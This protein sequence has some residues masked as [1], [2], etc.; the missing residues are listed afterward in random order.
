MKPSKCNIVPSS[1]ADTNFDDGGRERDIIASWLQENFPQRKDFKIIFPA[2]YLGFYLGPKSLDPLWAAPICKWNARSKGIAHSHMG[3]T[4]AALKYKSRA[5]S[6]LGYI[7]QLQPPPGS[8]FPSERAN[9]HHML[10]LPTNSWEHNAFFHLGDIGCKN[11]L[12]SMRI[13]RHPSSELRIKQ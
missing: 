12:A 10:H 7:A 8:I 3:S 9:L 2:K 11:F 4:L 13:A 6:V 5:V 1:Q